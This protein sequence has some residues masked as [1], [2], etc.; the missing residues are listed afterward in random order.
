MRR[1]CKSLSV[2]F[3]VLT[4]I[5]GVAL[6][7]S[8]QS[9]AK[10][11]GDV[12][13]KVGT[14]A[15]ALG[16]SAIKIALAGEND[17]FDQKDLLE[18][19]KDASFYS[20]LSKSLIGWWNTQVAHNAWATIGPRRLTLNSNLDGTLIGTSGRMFVSFPMENDKL[21]I[22][23]SERDGKAKTSVIV[24]K[25]YPDGKWTQLSTRW[26]NDTNDLQRKDNEVERIELSGVKG[27]EISV[28]A[29][30][31]SFSNTFEYTV[32]ADD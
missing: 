14:E 30:A 9:A 13:N 19:Y 10:V 1:F 25:H 7:Q 26:F 16:C 21:T 20:G 18:C 31:K 5:P 11:A 15:I 22:T 8:C 3:I 12:Y 2:S 27:Y 32:R 28:H 6:A 4:A 29:D 17:S 23:V 24:C